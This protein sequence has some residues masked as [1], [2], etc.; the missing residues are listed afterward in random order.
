MSDLIINETNIPSMAVYWTHTDNAL[1]KAIQF[2]KGGIKGIKD[3]SFP[4]HAGLFTRDNGILFGT[5]ETP[6]GLGEESVRQYNR[7]S[8]RIICVYYWSG[9]K[10]E[11]LNT[12]AQARLTGL[13]AMHGAASKYN[14][15]AL[16]AELPVV[17][18]AFNWAWNEPGMICSQAVAWIHR[19]YGCNWLD[20]EKI[21]PDQLLE[22]FQ[23][24]RKNIKDPKQSVDCILGYYK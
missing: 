21:S 14:Y 7:P 23:W 8:D 12:E 5:E 13:R 22:K 16:L 20:T 24:A 17:G 18:K 1:G 15:W 19:E 9:W 11:R 4:N 6:S 2:C 3:K 10:N